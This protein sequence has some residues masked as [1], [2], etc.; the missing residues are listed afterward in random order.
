MDRP[1][2]SEISAMIDQSTQIPCVLLFLETV[3]ARLGTPLPEQIRT[4]KAPIWLIPSQR[5]PV[6]CPQ[7][8]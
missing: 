4:Q 6:F 2:N 5:R 8:A 7:R 1:P 3:K